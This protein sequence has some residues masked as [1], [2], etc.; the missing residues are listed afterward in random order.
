LYISS[1][2]DLICFVKEKYSQR[3]NI[4]GNIISEKNFLDIFSGKVYPGNFI[5]PRDNK[6]WDDFTDIY[7]HY[8]ISAG[9]ESSY[10]KEFTEAQ[11]IVVFVKDKLYA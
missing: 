10:G 4:K 1:F 8:P 9:Y 3:S 2:Y 5:D 11:K 7:H 6:W